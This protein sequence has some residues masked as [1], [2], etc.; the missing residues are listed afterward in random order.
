MERGEKH[1]KNP[2]WIWHDGI[3]YLFPKGGNI[4]AVSK[5]R[6]E[7]GTISTIVLT[8]KKKYKTI[9]SPYV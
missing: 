5:Y 3:G 7:L 1:Y 8:G 9:F 4:V 2:E 6:V